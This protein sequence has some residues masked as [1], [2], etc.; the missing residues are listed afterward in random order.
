MAAEVEINTDFEEE[1]T[2]FINTEVGDDVKSLGKVNEIRQQ[3]M[4]QKKSLE[5]RL[6]AASSEVPQRI[7]EALN[8]AESAVKRMQELAIVEK[9]TRNDITRHLTKAEPI[10][11][12]LSKMTNQVKELE[13]YMNYMKWVEE[14]E[15]LSSEIQLSLVAGG[16]PSAVIHFADLAELSEAIQGSSCHNLI[17]FV[18]STVLFW[19]KILKDNISS[20]FDEVLKILRWPFISSTVPGPPL[21]NHAELILKMETL[22]GQLLK[23][24]LPYPCIRNFVYDNLCSDNLSSDDKSILEYSSLPGCRPILLPLQLLLN[25]LKKRFKYHFYGKKQTNN[26]S[27]PEWYF[28]QVLNWIRDHCTFLDNTV[29]PMLNKAGLAN[30][31]ARVEFIRGLMVIVTSKLSQDIPD[32]LYDENLLSHTIDEALLFDREVRSNF[33]YSASQPGCL[34][35]LT[36]HDCYEKWVNVEKKFAVEKTDNLL[37]SANAWT[38]QYKDISDVDELKVPEC[39]ENFMTLLLVI[40]DRYKNLPYPVHRLRFLELQLELLDDFRIRLLQVMKEESK[41]PLE[42]NFSAILN[43]L[44]YVMVVLQEWSEQVFFLHLQYFKMEQESFN[45]AVEQSQGSSA[46]DQSI[47]TQAFDESKLDK[48]EGTVFDEIINLY[49]ILRHEMVSIMSAAVVDDVK[50]KSRSY[51]VDKWFSMPSQKNFIVLGLSASA[52]DMLQML[53]DRLHLVQQQVCLSIFNTIWQKVAESLNK[54]IYEEVILSNRFNEG[55]AAQLQYDMTRNLF[56]MF[57]EYTQRPDNYFKDVKEACILLNLNLGSAILLRD[58][59]FH[60]L[61]ED[62]SDDSPTTPKPRP[63]LND[64]GVYR[65]TPASAERILNLRTDWPKT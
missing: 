45:T 16:I 5:E 2:Y 46:L 4:E 38:S 53:K 35:I 40:T 13:K 31:D 10:I 21:P 41:V 28:T 55:G 33:G 12:E 19:Y 63:A 24:Q 37:A 18:S 25:P 50:A 20:E 51:R 30:L 47:L 59:L 48:M 44:N 11:N 1:V 58:V 17:D 61:H 34:H 39:A 9:E 7:N 6:S 56:P 57:G 22:F 8:D 62:T 26:I 15:K 27:K 3:L 52:C 36:E 29:Q 42:P 23:L 14:V 64:I 49:K 32:L 54:F 43:A 60:A 65:L